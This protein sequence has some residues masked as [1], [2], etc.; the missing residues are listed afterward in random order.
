VR[1]LLDAKDLINVVEHS[2]PVKLSELDD[3]LRARNARLVYSLG[4][5][6]GLAAPL[7]I[8]SSHLP[9]IKEYIGQLE[10]LPHCFIGSDI[11]L[12]ELRSALR[13]FE[14]SKEYEPV[15][16]F[17]PRFD[18]VFPRFA[19]PKKLYYPMWD[20]VPDLWRAC[21]HIFKPQHKFHEILAFAM[22]IDREKPVARRLPVEVPAETIIETLMDKMSVTKERATEV[23]S[24]IND[25]GP[26][27]CPAMW[28]ARALGSAMSQNRTYSARRDDTFDMAEMW[29]IPYVEA[30]TVDRTM[31]DWFSRARRNIER[32]G[33][34]VNESPRVFK[35]LQDL[36]AASPVAEGAKNGDV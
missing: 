14:A 33:G 2:K 29:A 20:S 21:P 15:N 4:N 36:M 5:I 35:S 34:M 25:G 11:N 26:F 19:N 24:W 30:A 16:P 17:V 31:L 8:D 7:A 22:S 3:W 32:K 12:I 13:C 23:A 1:I 27:R 10:G 28:L 9:R 18:Y 6:R